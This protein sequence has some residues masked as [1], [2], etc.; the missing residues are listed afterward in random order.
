MKKA[1]IVG[2]S[3]GIGKE[4]AKILSDKGYTLGL[5]SRRKSLLEKLQAELP[6]KSLIRSLDIT[7]MNS[8]EKLK[9]L[10]QEM[11]GVDLIII[12]AGCIYINQELD[13]EKEKKT[14]DLNVSAFTAVINTAYKY[15]SKRGKG[16]IVGIS[17]IAAL[18]GADDAPAYHASKAYVSNYME[19]LRVK[20]E[21]ENLSLKITD[22]KPGYVDTDMAVKDNQFWVASAETAASQIFRAIEKKK[23]H[24]Y[25]TKRWRL[26]A[27]LLK[28][29]PGFL[30]KKIL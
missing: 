6:N 4:L 11:D 3:S 28:I 8:I 17:S 9:R 19:G 13:F 29:I 22:I 20:A 30:Y 14:I 5:V 25:I 16:H 21:K 27:W 15:F 7:S 24:A 12:S 23:D 26:A 2:A 18:R 1:V 10:I